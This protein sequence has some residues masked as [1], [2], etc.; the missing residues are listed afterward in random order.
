MELEFR[1]ME[2]VCIAVGLDN[3]ET[4]IPVESPGGDGC[5]SKDLFGHLSSGEVEGAWFV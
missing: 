2:S 5:V 4:N 1:G 3:V